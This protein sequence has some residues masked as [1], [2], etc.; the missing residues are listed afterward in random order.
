MGKRPRRQKARSSDDEYAGREAAR[1]ASLP[2]YSL[3]SYDRC[4]RTLLYSEI[5]VYS[6]KKSGIVAR[7]I[8][9]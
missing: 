8:E 3:I 6:L 1:A 9:T 4:T 2:A 7:R 5:K